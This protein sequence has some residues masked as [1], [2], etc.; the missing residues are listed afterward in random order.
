MQGMLALITTCKGRL[1]HL[2]ESLPFFVKQFP[3]VVVVDYDCPDGTAD[4]IMA[5][6]HDTCVAIKICNQPLF[7]KTKA[8]NA[9]AREAMAL[10]A[11]R[12]V[13]ADADTLVPDTLAD[14]LDG[15]PEYEMVLTEPHHALIG[16]LSVSVPRFRLVSGYDERYI[17]WGY[18]DLDMRLRLYCDASCGPKFIPESQFRTIRHTSS[19]RIRFQEGTIQDS[20]ARNRILYKTALRARL[21]H[22]SQN[23]RDCLPYQ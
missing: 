6:E 2:K 11:T 19:E 5:N 20:S 3:L 22:W 10:G 1:S 8:L 14:Y 23:L 16:F 18:E 17:G 4:W 21:L 12:L 15:R 13:F 9:G 7:H